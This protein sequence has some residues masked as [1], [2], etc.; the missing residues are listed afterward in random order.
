MAWG[1]GKDDRKPNTLASLVERN[2]LDIIHNIVSAKVI[3]RFK[4]SD[5]LLK[6][7]FLTFAPYLPQE[8]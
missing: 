4:L 8:K 7:V 6:T 1:R 3:Y 2:G 5:V